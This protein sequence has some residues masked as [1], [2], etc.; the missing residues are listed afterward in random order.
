MSGV[1]IF[2]ASLFLFHPDLKITRFSTWKNGS[3]MKEDI[4]LPELTP[5]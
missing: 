4:S 1:R 3:G 2:S 5:V